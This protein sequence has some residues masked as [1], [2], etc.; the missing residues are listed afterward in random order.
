MDTHCKLQSLK[1]LTKYV[2]RT[3]DEADF[4]AAMK[5][6]AGKSSGGRLVNGVLIATIMSEPSVDIYKTYQ[7]R[8]LDLDEVK[9]FVGKK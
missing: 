8:F 7:R 6:L 4:A 5:L 2:D 1:N 3:M 9:R